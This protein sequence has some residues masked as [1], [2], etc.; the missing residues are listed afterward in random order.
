MDALS[1]RLEEIR[2]ALENNGFSSSE[3]FT[4][5]AVDM[6]KKLTLAA[7][8]RMI[9]AER[10]GMSEVEIAASLPI[11]MSLFVSMLVHGFHPDGDAQF[12]ERLL[13]R[14]QDICRRLGDAERAQLPAMPA[15][16]DRCH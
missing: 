9:E 8:E 15:V 13:R 11:A 10:D 6:G 7:I 2:Y 5:T 14:V 3:G 16:S 1:S 4:D 12:I